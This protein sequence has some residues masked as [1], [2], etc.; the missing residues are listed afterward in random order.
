MIPGRGVH[1]VPQS[2]T[3]KVVPGVQPGEDVPKVLP[4][5]V[6]GKK[7]TRRMNKVCAE[8]AKEGSSP[9]GVLAR[10]WMAGRILV[11]SVEYDF[12]E[13]PFL[14]AELSLARQR[15]YSSTVPKRNARV[16]YLS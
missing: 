1:A 4:L 13:L 11:C 9:T 12:Q 3:P 16:P 2:S 8:V 7:D 10:G 5:V 14:T 15:R 6:E